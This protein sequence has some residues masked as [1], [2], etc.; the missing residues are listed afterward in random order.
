MERAVLLEREMGAGA[1]VIISVGP[2]DPARMGF[3]Q[4]HDVI[5]TFSPD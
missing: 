2:E 1:I 4:D 3:A 5:R